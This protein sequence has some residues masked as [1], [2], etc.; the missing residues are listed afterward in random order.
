M[1]D[2]RSYFGSVIGLSPAG[3]PPPPAGPLSVEEVRRKLALLPADAAVADVVPGWLAG[4]EAA[5]VVELLLQ[6]DSPT[7]AQRALQL[8]EWLRALPPDSPH[9]HLC[10]P[11]TFA[12]MI[13]LYGRWR[14]PKAVRLV[15]SFLLSARNG[16]GGQARSRACSGAWPVRSTSLP[17]DVAA[18]PPLLSLGARRR[19]ACLRS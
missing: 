14:R 2:L 9:A 17:V 1:S 18:L 3:E 4:W 19:C 7:T 6:L 11:D 12:A 13:G 5:G 16:I 10:T 15:F 8:F